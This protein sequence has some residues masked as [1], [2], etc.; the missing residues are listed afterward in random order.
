[1]V[2]N[3]AKKAIFLP[4]NSI[5]AKGY[6]AKADKITFKTTVK[7][8]TIKLFK[9]YFTIGTNLKTSLKFLKVKS[10][11]KKTGG[12]AKM[13]S[14]LPLSAVDKSHRK[15]IKDK[16]QTVIK[17]ICIKIFL[18]FSDFILYIYPF[19]KQKYS[20]LKIPLR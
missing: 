17:T 2:A 13:F 16:M 10:F 7:P 11:G 4:L 12:Y 9:T 14:L 3:I 6:A 18:N 19:Q 5:L 20:T 1:M 15:G 8:A